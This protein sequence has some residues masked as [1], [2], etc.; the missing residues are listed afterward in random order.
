M[1]VE[2]IEMT[3]LILV[4]YFKQS[5]GFRPSSLKPEARPKLSYDG[6][7]ADSWFADA[8][9][10]IPVSRYCGRSDASRDVRVPP[11]SNAFQ[12]CGSRCRL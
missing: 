11:T 12:Q 10:T 1:E 3:V 2:F 8:M 5:W 4:L 9:Q 7:Y 6:L